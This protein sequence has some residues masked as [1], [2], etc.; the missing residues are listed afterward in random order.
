MKG[1]TF[2]VAIDDVGGTPYIHSGTSGDGFGGIGIL[3][4]IAIMAMF[5]GGFGGGWG[6]GG[7]RGELSYMDGSNLENGIMARTD[8]RFNSL[9]NMN[10]FRSMTASNERGFYAMEEQIRDNCDAICQ[11]NVRI[12]EEGHKNALIEK[13]TQLQI[14]LGFKDAE[15]RAA[16]CCCETNRH[17]DAVQYDLATKIADCCCQ[18]RADTERILA[19]N[20]AIA[21]QFE[22]A[23]LVS[24][25]H[26]LE[27]LIPTPTI[28]YAYPQQVYAPNA[29]L[30]YGY[31]GCANAVGAGV[32]F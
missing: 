7:C 18:N 21:N 25:I 32:A 12:L 1:R 4:L 3:G 22:K 13:D 17:L 20:L 11:T 19:S 9:E 15:L 31:N 6:G 23:A 29:T 14:A 26:D 2:I 10:E 30:G 8:A 5:G 28:Q 24:K 27:R 16:E